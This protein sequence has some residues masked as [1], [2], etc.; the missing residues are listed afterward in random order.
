MTHDMYARRIAFALVALAWTPSLTD[1]VAA[2]GAFTDTLKIIGSNGAEIRTYAFEQLQ[3]D[4]TAKEITTATP[5]S[6]EGVT[7]TYRGI[8]LDD[9]LQRYG[10]AQGHDTITVNAADDFR[11]DI[12]IKMIETYQPIIALERGCVDEDYEARRCAKGQ[13]M[14][15]LGPKDF[16]PLFLVWPRDDVPG[17]A[18]AYNS[19]WVWFIT[20]LTVES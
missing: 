7:Y 4:F 8:A 10:L 5:W 2:Q 15:K 6:A 9:I 13:T 20:N 14:M 3:A 16:G 19:Y 17:A 1:D 12:P 11:A 18:D